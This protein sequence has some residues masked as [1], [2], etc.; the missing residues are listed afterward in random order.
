MHHFRVLE[1]AKV[2]GPQA[3]EL[4]LTLFIVIDQRRVDFV[5]VLHLVRLGLHTITVA[6]HELDLLIWLVRILLMEEEPEISNIVD[7]LFP[8]ETVFDILINLRVLVGVDVQ[9]ADLD[10]I[11][12]EKDSAL[13]LNQLRVVHV[14]VVKVVHVADAA[15]GLVEVVLDFHGHDVQP[16]ASPVIRVSH[17]SVIQVP[18]L[19]R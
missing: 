18:D 9:H 5:A 11:L 3:N 17:Y 1:R 4:S 7:R 8:R 19:Q 16:W 10:D 2:D 12:E 13:V 6:M 14:I 15:H